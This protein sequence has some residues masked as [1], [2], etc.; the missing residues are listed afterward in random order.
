MGH[1]WSKRHEQIPATSEQLPQGQRTPVVLVNYV[2]KG[3]A[4][5]LQ[6][7]HATTKATPSQTHT[8]NEGKS[9]LSFSLSEP[10]NTSHG[11]TTVRISMRVIFSLRDPLSI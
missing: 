10:R 4:T 6:D 11:S 7:S 3:S 8:Q 2:R 9:F 5:S 1:F